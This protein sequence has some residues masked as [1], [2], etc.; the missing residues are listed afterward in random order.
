MYKR[1]ID[2][3]WSFKDADTKEF[4]HCY[5]AYPAMMIPQVARALIEEYKPEDGVELLFDPYMGSGTSLVEASIKGINA[6]GTDLNPLARLM[7]HV[8]TTHYDLS[9]I[10]DTFS[11]MQALFFE[12]SEDKVKNKNF[13][14]I[15]N[16][17]YWYSRD[18]LLRLSYIYQVINECVALDF[19]DFFKIGDGKTGITDRFQI[20]Q[21]GFF[22]DGIPNIFCF[23]AFGKVAG[24]AE[25]F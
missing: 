15:S 19:A 7:S 17:T 12:Y 24:D 25:S 10:R 16:Y 2:N 6:I 1:T 21:T 22:I 14:N 4:T 11:M 13:D 9:C 5:H 18:S 20:D 3:R 8:K 23:V